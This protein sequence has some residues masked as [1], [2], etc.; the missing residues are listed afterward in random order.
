MPPRTAPRKRSVPAASKILAV[1]KEEQQQRQ[2]GKQEPSTWTATDATMTTSKKKPRRSPSAAAAAGSGGGQKPSPPPQYVGDSSS[3]EE[4]EGASKKKKS[5]VSLGNVV[6]FER[7]TKRD[8]IDVNAPPA[9]A[10]N[11]VAG[12]PSAGSTPRVSVEN[13]PSQTLVQGKPGPCA[14]EGG[15]DDDEEDEGDAFADRSGGGAAADA[16]ADADATGNDAKAAASAAAAAPQDWV[17]SGGAT[18]NFAPCPLGRATLLFDL[19]GVLLVN[20]RDPASGRR[21]PRLRPGVENLARLCGKFRLG[22]YSSATL[23]TVRRA[24]SAVVFGMM[25]GSSSTTNNQQ[26]QQQQQVFE[27][28]LCRQHCRPAPKVRKFDLSRPRWRPFTPCLCAILVAFDALRPD[29]FLF[30][31]A[32]VTC[33]IDAR[34][35]PGCSKSPENRLKSSLPTRVFGLF[36][37][38]HALFVLFAACNRCAA[39]R[40]VI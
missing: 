4:D 20:P 7:K 34:E 33:A 26:Q 38:F 18:G 9:A 23:Q 24:T 32:F 8:A 11:G 27:L 2:A 37:T 39:L 21:V 12:A 10:A 19:N 36:T 30:P 6:P 17:A 31:D 13:F 15:I 40:G 22:V 5:V 28:M 1:S 3:S 35:R 25:S 29:A 14:M 16:D